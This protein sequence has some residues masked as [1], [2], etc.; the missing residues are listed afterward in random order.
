M[1]LKAVARLAAA[2]ALSFGPRC[3]G[4]SK[5]PPPNTSLPGQQKLCQKQTA[6]RRLILHA[7]A[8]HDPVLVVVAISQV[9]IGPGALE[10]DGFDAGKVVGD[11]AALS[12]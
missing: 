6:K 4:R 10:G 9:R 2:A 12:Y 1:K 3:Q 8:Q 7:L 5:V 11:H